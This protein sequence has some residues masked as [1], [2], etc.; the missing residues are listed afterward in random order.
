VPSTTGRSGASAVAGGVVPSFLS[1]GSGVG[2]VLIP[3][4]PTSCLHR[5]HLVWSSARDA[6]IEPPDHRH[7]LPLVEQRRP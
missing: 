3:D 1:V 5:Q 6:L 2:S 4:A 7:P